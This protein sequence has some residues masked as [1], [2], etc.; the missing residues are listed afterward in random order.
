[1][2][3]GE[4]AAENQTLVDLVRGACSHRFGVGTPSQ[5]SPEWGRLDGS[6]LR[7]AAQEVS[8]SIASLEQER[9]HILQL[10]DERGAFAAEGS[11]D[12]ADWAAS[13]LGMSRQAAVGQLDLARQLDDLPVLAEK[14]AR[15]ELSSDQ[16]GPAAQLAGAARQHGDAD[17][18]RTW[19]TNAPGMGV[20]A[21]RRRAGKARRP[22]AA[23][24]ADARRVRVFESWRA[25]QELRFRGSVPID[26]G[27]VLLKAIERSMPERDPA[28]PATLGQRQADGL[29][30]LASVTVADDADPDRATVIAIVELAAICDDD[31][32]ATAE[33]ETGEPLATDTARRLVCDS[34]L[35]VLVQDKAGRAVGL[36]T[37]ARTVTPALRRALVVRDGHCRFGDCTSRR[38]L[39][40]HHITHWPAPTVM[41]NLAM[42]CYSH[43][44]A[45]HE[46]GWHLVGDP[47]GELIAVH[48]D[49]RR[50]PPNLPQCLDTADLDTTVTPPPGAPPT[51]PPSPGR[52]PDPAAPPPAPHDLDQAAPEREAADE[53]GLRS[54]AG[55]A[56]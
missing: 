51:S 20:D 39:H 12:A 37:T 21:L 2:S 19:A 24:H 27:A 45:L 56:R 22:G 28:N 4:A 49:G 40:G 33:L 7:R 29:L 15:G 9:R 48:H 16:A 41:S 52:P 6:G 11:R 8:R 50:S 17:A 55:P 53:V 23:D 13:R 42:V 31:P 3:V 1:M 26:S 35:S 54:R 43:H 47:A 25:G 46:G 18:D 36:G 10:I 14:A 44:H 5:G 30:A 32:Q 34:R 38:F